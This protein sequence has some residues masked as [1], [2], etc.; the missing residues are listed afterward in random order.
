MGSA[1]AWTWA[2]MIGSRLRATRRAP[3]PIAPEA[4]ASRRS[5]AAISAE[6]SVSDLCSTSLASSTPPG[7]RS[8]RTLGRALAPPPARTAR[9]SS[10]ASDGD[11]RPR[12]GAWRSP[13]AGVGD[14]PAGASRSSL[15]HVTRGTVL[16]EPDARSPPPVSGRAGASGTAAGRATPRGLAAVA[17]SVAASAGGSPAV[18]GT[19]GAEPVGAGTGV[20][21]GSGAGDGAGAGAGAGAG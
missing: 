17:G 11:A 21:A 13:D 9:G 1:W 8:S 10:G 5:A 20:G 15:P 19:G 14:D 4:R 16:D 6:R 2:P 12:R 18:G 7:R 3:R